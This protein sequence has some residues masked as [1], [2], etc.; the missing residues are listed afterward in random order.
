MDFFKQKWVKI[1]GFVL[2][3]A[4]A[5]LLILGGLTKEDI[6]KTVAL[7]DGIIIAVGTLITAIVAFVN[8]KELKKLQGK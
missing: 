1:V 7:V 4:G 3:I 8:G 5:V 2:L 6:S